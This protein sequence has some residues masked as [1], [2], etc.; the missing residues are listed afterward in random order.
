MKEEWKRWGE[1]KRVKIQEM[2]IE[3][4]QKEGSGDVYIGKG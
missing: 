3:G 4:K 2:D 1:S